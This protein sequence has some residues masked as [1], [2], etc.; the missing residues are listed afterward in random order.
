MSFFTLDEQHFEIDPLRARIQD[1]RLPCQLERLDDALPSGNDALRKSE[2]NTVFPVSSLPPELLSAVFS[3]VQRMSISDP[4]LG[5][6][7]F[8]ITASHVSSQWRTLALS[9]GMLWRRINITPGRS[10]LSVSTYLARAGSCPLEVRLDLTRAVPCL[11]PTH[12]PR[13]LDMVFAHADHWS[14]FSIESIHDSSVFPIIARLASLSAPILEY[15]SISVIPVENPESQG[16]I[17]PRIWRYPKLAAVRLR[18]V[19]MIYFWPPLTTV[20]TLHL[21]QTKD[22]VPLRYK[23]LH[24]LL[25]QATSLTNLSIYGQVIDVLEDPWRLD[26]PIKI[27]NLRSL[28]VCCAVG[29]GYSGILLG[30][31]APQ[32]ESLVLK[33]A[34]DNDLD[35]VFPVSD[36]RFPNLRSLTFYDFDFSVRTYKMLFTAFPRTVEFASFFSTARPPQVLSL[37]SKISVDVPWPDLHTLSILIDVDYGSAHLTDVLEAREKLGCPLKRL[38]LGTSD[39]L[40]LIDDYDFI[41]DRVTSLERFTSFDP[42]PDGTGNDADD[43]YLFLDLDD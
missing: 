37:L 40:D 9:T 2:S 41:Y 42:W 33:N 31:S 32:L 21:E 34:L 22:Y 35:P 12:L 15:L 11:E 24:E 36:T 7:A 30:I 18:G 43:D 29:T 26:T 20:T 19:A 25:S 5:D 28:R 3:L 23:E 10:V 4:E 14:Q 38:R 17:E 27:P 13:M 1:L 16:P 39:D 6:A 8:E